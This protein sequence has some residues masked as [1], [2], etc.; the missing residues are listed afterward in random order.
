[1]SLF[2]LLQIWLPFGLLEGWAP[3]WRLAVLWLMVLTLYL[4]ARAILRCIWRRLWEPPVFLCLLA[5]LVSVGSEVWAKHLQPALSS[6]AGPSLFADWRVTAALI[7]LANVLFL[8]AVLFFKPLCSTGVAMALAIGGRLECLWGK[9]EEKTKNGSTTTI[10][11][12]VPGAGGETVIAAVIAQLQEMGQQLMQTMDAKLEAKLEEHFKKLGEVVQPQAT[13]RTVELPVAQQGVTVRPVELPVAP[14]QVTVRTPELPVPTEPLTSWS[15]VVAGSPLCAQRRY[16]PP[17]ATPVLNRYSALSED[18]SEGSPDTSL[19]AT[20]ATLHTCPLL[21]QIS[22]QRHAQ[23]RRQARAPARPLASTSSQQL[24]MGDGVQELL[25]RY[26]LPDEAALKDFLQWQGQLELEAT[27]DPEFLTAEER[28]FNTLAELAL[29]WKKQDLRRGLSTKPVNVYDYKV[30][31]GTLTADMKE[32]MRR[33]DLKKLIKQRK[34]ERWIADQVAKGVPLFECEHCLRVDKV[35]GH[36]CSVTGWTTGKPGPLTSRHV[37]I[38]QRPNSVTVQPAKAPPLEQLQTM[39]DYS[40]AKLAERAKIAQLLQPPPV[41]ED[42]PMTEGAPMTDASSSTLPTT[43]PT[44]TVT[45][46]GQQPFS[47]EPTQSTTPG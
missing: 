12:L 30:D 35:N 42:V 45:S 9:G 36:R 19:L 47:Q 20:P 5:T 15:T 28:Q 40:H 39:Y 8:L 6:F 32:K 43:A 27:K 26:D 34:H 16:Q 25:E 17:A 24:N 14:P 18:E 33:W 23:P 31:L 13:V 4:A 44:I 21:P 22:K 10:V 37:I 38:T 2:L 1:M 41:T 3:G 29:H 46:P 11:N 7:A